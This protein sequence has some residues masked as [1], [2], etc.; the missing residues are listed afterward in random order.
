MSRIGK[1]AIDIPGG[2]SVTVNPND[3]VVEGPKG[4]L[5]QKNRHNVKA[6]LEK[7]KLSVQK[8]SLGSN[9]NAFWGLYKRL[10]ENMVTGVTQGYKKTL[11]IKGVGYRADVKGSTLN[12][13]VGF[14]HPVNYDLPSG[15]KCSVE[16][17]TT[18][19]LESIDKQLIGQTAANIRALRPP[20]PYKGKGIAY[21]D[22]V[23]KRKEGKT[24]KK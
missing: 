5:I 9:S 6:I 19:H 20:E 13:Q 17:Q 7:N 22:E 21:S 3:I 16:K 15:V 2:V 10:I 11:V 8:P 12:L 23:I 18:L 24:G 4:K 1:R 14:S